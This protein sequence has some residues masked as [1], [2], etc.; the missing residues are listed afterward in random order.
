MAYKDFIL[1]LCVK[2]WIKD[3]CVIHVVVKRFVTYV[4]DKPLHKLRPFTIYVHCHDTFDYK[5][6]VS[7][8]KMTFLC[9]KRRRL[10]SCLCVKC[11]NINRPMPFLRA[12]P[13]RG[14]LC[15]K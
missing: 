7:I 12:F 8:E 13:S 4:G 15:L 9:S 14:H 1:V 3:Y 10:I 11:A 5:T 6:T 2:M